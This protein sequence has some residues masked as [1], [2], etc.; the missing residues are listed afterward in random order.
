MRK[1]ARPQDKHQAASRRMP[2]HAINSRK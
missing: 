2:S 1:R